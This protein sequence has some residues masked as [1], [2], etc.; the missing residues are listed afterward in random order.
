M[1]GA[2]AAAEAAYSGARSL[3]GVLEQQRVIRANRVASLAEAFVY[4]IKDNEVVALSIIKFTP[5]FVRF[6]A[7]AK[8]GR[9]EPMHAYAYRDGLN[10]R[11]GG[12]AYG[13]PAALNGVGHAV[14]RTRELAE[15]AL[16]DRQRPWTRARATDDKARVIRAAH[17]AMDLRGRGKS[18]VHITTEACRV[19]R[20]LLD[21][22]AAMT[23]IDSAEETLPLEVPRAGGNA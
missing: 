9:G 3:S 6:D 12:S 4:A 10:S 23:G 11:H 21:V 17:R 16:A 5:K 20:E 22:L 18:G 1:K 15:R 14:Y 2:T 19:I 8:T 13:C 7:G